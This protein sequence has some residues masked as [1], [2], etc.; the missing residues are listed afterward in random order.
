M[1]APNPILGTL[2]HAIGATSAAV[3][4]TPQKRVKGWSWQT[5][6]MTQAFV[7][8]FLLPILG[9][10]ITIPELAAVLRE[11]PRNAM[12]LSFVLG[13]AY[14]FG[15]TA[16][17]LAIRYLGFSLTYALAI[18]LSCVLGTIIPPMVRGQLGEMFARSG[19]TWILAGLVA[20]A[21]GFLLCGLAG[22]FKETDTADDESNKDFSI[23]KGVPLC[24]LAGV[25]S[26]VYGFSLEAGVPIANVAEAHGAGEFSGNV[27][28]IFS[29][30]G[31]FLTTLVYCLWLHKKHKTLGELI[32]LPAGEEQ[33]SLPINF[34][35][36]VLTGALW[37]G[38]F[39]FYNLAHVRMGNF[40]FT[41]WAIHM[42][43][44]VL[45]SS[46]LGL[47]L[48]EWKGC[49]KRTWVILG[50]SLGALIIAVL[51]LTYGSRL[52]ELAT[53]H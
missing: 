53:G 46:L 22:R 20:G 12:V 14:G 45:I 6:W 36:A 1:I 37:Y 7:C 35:M 19:S 47:V 38:Q 24:I 13:I 17:G 26:A 29:N 50:G 21:I 10:M 42:I 41:S 32:E 44:L 27:V 2:I 39:F 25:L 51:M 28:F 52:A 30:T 23:I 4:Y 34:A 31:A 48:R 33:A 3:C 49:K 40:K 8:W 9:A 11:A 15:G 18:G 5:Y 43:M 16:F